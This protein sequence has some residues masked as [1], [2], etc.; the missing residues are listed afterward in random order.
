MSHVKL[1]A[2][3]VLPASGLSS[4]KFLAFKTCIIGYILQIIIYL[5]INMK[6]MR[7]FTMSGLPFER[8]DGY[9]SSMQMT[10]TTEKY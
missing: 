10:L 1:K 5:F 4:T 2:P 8:V 6:E 3:E 7:T 9:K